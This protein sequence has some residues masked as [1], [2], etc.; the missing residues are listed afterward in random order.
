MSI[1]DNKY[2]RYHEGIDDV[3]GSIGIQFLQ[4][5]IHNDSLNPVKDWGG[6]GIHVIH[7]STKYQNFRS[8]KHETKC[9]IYKLT[10]LH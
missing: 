3:T 9:K 5:I 2:P 8:L 4:K 7:V 10:T 1:Y 6:L